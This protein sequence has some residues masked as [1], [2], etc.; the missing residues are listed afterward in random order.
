MEAVSV[1]R[2]TRPSNRT[3]RRW[4][5]L[6]G[7]LTAHLCR[8]STRDVRVHR[9]CQGLRPAL[10]AELDSV[11]NRG[12]RT[13]MH[14]HTPPTHAREVVLFVGGQPM[15]WARSVALQRS[16][17]GPWRAVR[18]LGSRPLAEL[19]Y[20]S[21]WTRRSPLRLLR[22]G[23]CGPWRRHIRRSGAELI[24]SWGSQ[25]VWWARYSVFRQSGQALRVMEVF[26]PRIVDL[27]PPRPYGAVGN[28]R[29]HALKPA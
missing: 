20:N 4:L 15:V 3:L 21:P 6:P 8:S 11:L 29:R 12:T 16:V 22:I 26:S 28:T 2:P 23:P 7:S 27:Q 18:S 1:R 13:G 14:R 5:S 25:R 17:Y 10:P 24:A 19:L 9:L